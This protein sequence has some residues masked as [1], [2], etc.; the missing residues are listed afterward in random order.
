MPRACLQTRI[1]WRKDGAFSRAA[2]DA[3]CRRPVKSAPKV[4][5]ELGHHIGAAVCRHAL[6]EEERAK[7]E[8]A[9]RLAD[10]ER[11][12]A[13]TSRQLAE[14]AEARAVEEES[15]RRRFRSLFAGAT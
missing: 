8:I 12:R 13:E 10:E 15:G 4:G 9:N 14:A 6:V 11:A 1:G 2:H 7:A 3:P 5:Q